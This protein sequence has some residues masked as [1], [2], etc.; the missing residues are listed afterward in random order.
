MPHLPSTSQAASTAVRRSKLSKPQQDK[1]EKH[2]SHHSEA[3][4]DMM[5]DL[6]FKGVSFEK[7]HAM[8]MKKV[9]K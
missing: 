4:M 3:H 8:A 9:G 2:A 7:A 6:M 5:L 1:L